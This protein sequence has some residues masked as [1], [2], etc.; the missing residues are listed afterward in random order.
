MNITPIK[1]TNFTW[2]VNVNYAKNDNKV[3]SIA[4]NSPQFV[5]RGDFINLTKIVEGRPYGEMYS[6]GLLRDS[7]TG[8]QIVLDDGR[9]A[10]TGAQNVYLGNSR[11]KWT[12]GINNRFTYKDFSLSF[13][14]SARMGG[15]ITSFTDAN[16]EGDGLSARTLAGREGFIID[17]I[18]ADKS[19]NTTSITV[20]QYWNV[21]G[22]RNTPAGELFTYDASNIRVREL[23][24]S[25]N[26]PASKLSR[27]PIK[28]ASISFTGRNL[29][30]LRNDAKGFDPELVVS[31]DKGSIGTES[32]CLPY[33]RTFGLN[34]NL[35]F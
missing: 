11:P 22:G 19:K 23:V 16:L 3:I 26:I 12:G 21:L 18:K 34:L 28:G 29:F 4:P 8:Q 9:P 33:T 30:F 2:L 17:G 1:T 14:I 5:L 32:F 31:T 20:E 6:R 13:L 27:T 35:N 7:A 25:Y 15:R 10:V 24:L